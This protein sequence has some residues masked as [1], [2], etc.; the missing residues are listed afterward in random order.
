MMGKLWTKVGVVLAGGFLLGSG[1]ILAAQHVQ[2][3][4]TNLTA[5]SCRSLP[6]DAFLTDATQK[7]AGGGAVP[8][9][10]PIPSKRGTDLTDEGDRD[11]FYTKITV[12]ALTA[13]ELRV[14]D[15]GS[16]PSDAVLCHGSSS[17]ATSIAT[18]RSHDQS[19]VVTDATDAADTAGEA[20]VAAD[21]AAAV[22]RGASGTDA[23][24]DSARTTAS[25]ALT[26]A[27]RALSSAASALDDA[28]QDLRNTANAA[29]TTRA[30]DEAGAAA[31]RA[32]LAAQVA[33]TAH[34]DNTGTPTQSDP[35]A[36]DRLNA[37][38]GALEAVADA[39]SGTAGTATNPGPAEQELDQAAM[40]LG[41]AAGIGHSS[42]KIRADVQPGDLSYILVASAN[43]APMLAVSFHGA[44]SAAGSLSGAFDAGNQSTTTIIVTAPGLLTLETTGTTD[45]MGALDNAANAEIAHADSGGSGGNFKLYAPVMDA[46]YTLYVEGQTDTISGS[47]GLEMDFQVAMGQIAALSGTVNT[48]TEGEPWGTE[49]AL[50]LDDDIHDAPAIQERSDT[51]IFVFTIADDNAGLLNVQAEDGATSPASDTTGTLYGPPGVKVASA[52]DGSGRHFRVRAPVQAMNIYAVEVSGTVGSYM[53]EVSLDTV[54]GTNGAALPVTGSTNEMAD[55]NCVGANANTAFE[56][57]PPT[58][59]NPAE[60]EMHLFDVMEAGALYIHSTGGTDTIG[61]L[62]GPDGSQLATDD[63]S[64]QGNNFRLAVQVTPGLYLLEVRGKDANT[65]G[66][67]ELVTNFVAGDTVTTPTTPGTGDNLQARVDELEDLLAE[68]RA[69]VETDA[70]GRLENPSGGSFRSGIGLISGWVCAA[71]EV[72]VE[73]S[74]GGVV[75]ETF[76]V[77]YGTSRPDVPLDPDADCTNANAGF[78]MTYNFNHLPEGEYTIQ[79]FADDE[80]FGAEQTFTVVHLTPFARTDTDRFLRDLPAGTCDVEDFPYDGDATRLRWEQSTQNFVIEDAG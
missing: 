21:A 19:S 66:A 3:H 32:E 60:R 9:T 63:N 31:R 71:N 22:A 58:G 26:T 36:Q 47:F 24:L 50:A 14:V 54:E 2:A 1:L 42:F 52:T 70:N 46:T 76:T 37:V 25:T 77:G 57:C 17:R 29:L 10:P 4:T 64:G 18:Y 68:C 44:I 59:R 45:T 51:D 55:G 40:T 61:T 39:L 65:R 53:L 43:A 67:Y 69:G 7:I 75:Q 38:A 56:I 27:R 41:D 5:P 48:I 72:T 49:P 6:A 11:F 8:T 74:R 15:T 73:I 13:G 62:F 20:Q 33:R 80:M 78:G 34:T 23:E 30:K 35:T 16:G 12:P 28:A 79:A